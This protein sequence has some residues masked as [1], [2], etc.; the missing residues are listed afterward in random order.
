MFR[1]PCSSHLWFSHLDWCL[2][3]AF[4]GHF[5]LRGS[6]SKCSECAKRCN[7]Q[8]KLT[9]HSTKKK[10]RKKKKGSISNQR[11]LGRT[12]TRKTNLNYN[13]FHK[14]CNIDKSERTKQIQTCVNISSNYKSERSLAGVS[15][16]EKKDL[17]KVLVDL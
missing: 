15:Y 12:Y 3:G 14:I 17:F 10:K 13:Y 8:V 16:A 5:L 4:T 2:D 7:P 9:H 1:K 6:T 11:Q